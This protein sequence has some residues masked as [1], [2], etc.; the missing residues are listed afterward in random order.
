MSRVR[1]RHSPGEMGLPKGLGVKGLRGL[2]DVTNG[3]TR[4]DETGQSTDDRRCD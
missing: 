3:L 2:D 1:P 4:H